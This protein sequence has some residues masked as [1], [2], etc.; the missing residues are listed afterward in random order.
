MPIP[1]VM[2]KAEIRKAD[3]KRCITSKRRLR[4]TTA[5]VSIA[6]VF[7]L[8][9]GGLPAEASETRAAWQLVESN[10]DFS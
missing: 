1:S 7:S 5:L 6:G 9:L 4:L 8:S 2:S 3:M 10:D